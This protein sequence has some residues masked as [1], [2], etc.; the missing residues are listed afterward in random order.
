VARAIGP[1]LLRHGIGFAGLDV[2]GDML[3]EVNT[4]N[5]GGIH[6]ADTLGS[7]P[8]G[9]IARR[10]IQILEATAASMKQRNDR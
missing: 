4:L 2:I 8:R 7:Q 5:P 6:W 10:T 3:V 9:S 1:H